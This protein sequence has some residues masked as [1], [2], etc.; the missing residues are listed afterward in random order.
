MKTRL[1]RIASSILASTLF[2]S[3]AFAASTGYT[4]GGTVT[5]GQGQ[6]NICNTPPSATSCASY[7]YQLCP[8]QCATTPC[9]VPHVASEC[10]P[11]LQPQFTSAYTQQAAAL[12]AAGQP[13]S[14]PVILPPA[15]A[16]RDGLALGTVF[17][18]LPIASNGRSVLTAGNGAAYQDSSWGLGFVSAVE[19]PRY[20]QYDEGWY[21]NLTMNHCAEYVWKKWGQIS[22]FNDIAHTAGTNY[23]WVV[24]VVGEGTLGVV[25]D[26]L[27]QGERW[28]A[29]PVALNGTPVVFPTTIARNPFFSV[30]PYWLANATDPVEKAIYQQF[31][32]YAPQQTIAFPSTTILNEVWAAGEKQYLEAAGVTAAT[33]ADNERRIAAFQALATQLENDSTALQ[34]YEDGCVHMMWYCRRSPVF[35]ALTNA[36]TQDQQAI[37]N[38]LVAE[39]S[40]D[41]RNGCLGYTFPVQGGKSGVPQDYVT[42]GSGSTYTFRA[43]ACDWT[44]H[45]FY[46]QFVDMFEPQ[47]EAAM[48][49]CLRD[50]GDDFTQLSSAPASLFADSRLWGV[51]YNH[52]LTQRNNDATTYVPNQATQSL[53][54]YRNS[55]SMEQYFWNYE[56]RDAISAAFQPQIQAAAKTFAAQTTNLPLQGAPPGTPGQPTYI[57]ASRQDQNSIGGDW[58]GGGYSYWAGWS[59][60]PRVETA[61]QASAYP[62]DPL[63]HVCSM[64]ADA[65]ASMKVTA[66]VFQNNMTLLDAALE[67]KADPPAAPG[68]QGNDTPGTVTLKQA[69]FTVMGNDYL[70]P[71]LQKVNLKEGSTWNGSTFDFPLTETPFAPSYSVIIPVLFIPLEVSAGMTVKIGTD[72]TASAMPPVYCDRNNLGF[73]VSTS[74]TPSAEVDAFAAVAVDLGIASA[75]VQGNLTLFKGAM[76]VTGAM[77]LSSAATN[78]PNQ[79]SLVLNTAASLQMT[80]LSGD[81]DLFAEVLGDRADVSLFSW[82]GFKQNVPLFNLTQTYPLVAINYR[83]NGTVDTVQ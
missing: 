26:A 63:P 65:G 40:Y 67:V 70:A 37:T 46:Q 51:A 27:T 45:V 43:N 18:A 48:A 8:T 12:T 6:T 77:R 21:A 76:P 60:T 68:A 2:P 17:N 50:T 62:T 82:D 55:T 36:V 13:A 34:N 66:T 64:A 59:V 30:N 58:F 54:D 52:A 16:Q 10:A 28:D 81:V 74:V 15:M 3:A 83:L 57:G 14:K 42:G 31:V 29:Q 23:G 39:W 33:F 38:A 53:S 80:E 32:Q 11:Y 78:D 47:V 20:G 7:A 25:W 61:Q 4:G 9:A 71:Q 44:P 73:S 69:H 49:Q 41:A 79:I 1:R 56:N 19:Y 24:D 72:F 35:Q 75:G 5:T 22:W